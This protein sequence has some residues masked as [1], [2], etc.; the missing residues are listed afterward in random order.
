MFSPLTGCKI[1]LTSYMLVGESIP[2]L[3]KAES[4][5]GIVKTLRSEVNEVKSQCLRRN[6]KGSGDGEASSSGQIRRPPGPDEAFSQAMTSSLVDI[7]SSSSYS[8]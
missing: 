8:R 2:P 6:K 3:N 7:R 1:L 4:A 5:Q